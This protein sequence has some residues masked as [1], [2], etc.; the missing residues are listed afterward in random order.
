MDDRK[1]SYAVKIRTL[2]TLSIT[3]AFSLGQPSASQLLACSADDHRK[4]QRQ[5]LLLGSSKKQSSRKISGSVAD[6]SARL[7]PQ[8]D[9]KVTSSPW[10]GDNDNSMEGPAITVS[11]WQAREQRTPVRGSA[12]TNS[13]VKRQALGLHNWTLLY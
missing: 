9:M 8:E 2:E 7:P 5:Q 10:H 12:L 11:C 1:N 13:K 3:A 6:R 4:R